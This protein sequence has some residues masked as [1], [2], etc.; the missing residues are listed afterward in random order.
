[1]S[2]GP[3]IEV[4]GPNPV[5]SYILSFS[6]FATLKAMEE[7]IQQASNAI[8]LVKAD[9][10]RTLGHPVRVR[11]L[12]LLQDGERSVGD[13]QAALNLDS[14]GASQHLTVLRRQGLLEGRKEGTS[15]FY[16]VKD[17]RTFQ[18]LETARQLLSA[19]FEETQALLEGLGAPVGSPPSGRR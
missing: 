9:L 11:I 12:E 18:L 10:F 6:K 5:D 4:A 16:S 17:A 15:V 7:K 1:M 13:L 8:H 19:R 2:R 14:G 3:E